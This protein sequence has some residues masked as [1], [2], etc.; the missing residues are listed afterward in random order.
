MAV[1][2]PR[3]ETTTGSPPASTSSARSGGGCTI[4]GAG[5]GIWPGQGASRVPVAGGLPCFPGDKPGPLSR[6]APPWRRSREHAVG[7]EEALH[8]GQGPR[9]PGIGVAGAAPEAALGA[10]GRLPPSWYLSMRRS[11]PGW[12]SPASS[13]RLPGPPGG[14][15]RRRR[16]NVRGR[17]ARG[18]RRSPRGCGCRAG[19]ATRPGRGARGRTPARER[20]TPGWSWPGRPA[21]ARAASTAPNRPS[22]MPTSASAMAAVAPATRSTSACSPP[23]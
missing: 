23:K 17:G 14:R 5:G 9:R 12:R 8:G 7:P 11:I 21:P 2:S 19:P 13:P 6:A 22:A 10:V 16:R 1:R 18:G 20:G 4:A 3:P 15:P